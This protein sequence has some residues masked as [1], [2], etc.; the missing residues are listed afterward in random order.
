MEQRRLLLALVLSALVVVAYDWLVLSKYRRPAEVAS[1]ERAPAEPSAP[2][3]ESARQP[4][5][6]TPGGEAAPPPPA[7]APPEVIV[8]TDDLRVHI[9]PVGARLTQV[10]LKRFRRT[11]A[12]DSGFLALVNGGA[13]L[14]GTLQLGSAG[15]DA[16]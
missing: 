5:V 2:L 11:I 14:T 4:G 15:N 7:D 10:E 1:T 8:E 9:T 16:A 12:P 13:L 3:P 6:E